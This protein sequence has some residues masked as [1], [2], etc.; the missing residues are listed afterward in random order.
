[1]RFFAREDDAQS[2]GTGFSGRSLAVHETQ[3]SFRTSGVASG[4]FVDGNVDRELASHARAAVARLTDLVTAAVRASDD[5]T[6]GRLDLILQQAE[7][8]LTM[9]DGA[10]PR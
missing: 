1:M 2:S 10:R 6:V 7:R 8:L 3:T 9:A 5:D 4:T